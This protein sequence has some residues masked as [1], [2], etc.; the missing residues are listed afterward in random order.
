MRD[1]MKKSGKNIF[2]NS[3]IQKKFEEIYAQDNIFVL[4]TIKEGYPSMRC[5]D[6]FY[7]DGAFW[8]VGYSFTN[9]AKDIEINPQ[10]SLSNGW[11]NFKGKAYNMGHPLD[12]KNK[13]IREKLIE[14]FKN[15][16]FL[17][18]NEVH[19]T[20]CY[21]KVELEHGFFH[22]E[23]KSYLIDFTEDTIEEKEFKPHID[24]DLV[25]KF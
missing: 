13:E 24:V 4:A 22:T 23:G 19:K 11:N 17:A 1:K 14:A 8:I 21:I 20:M 15:W 6:T 7:D 12:E 25:V 2:K 16:Y 9:K 18:N 3:Q 10:V 5:V